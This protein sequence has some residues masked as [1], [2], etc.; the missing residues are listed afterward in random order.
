VA[1]G[2]APTEMAGSRN[3]QRKH[4]IFPGAVGALRNVDLPRNLSEVGFNVGVPVE[5]GI[6]AGASCGV[7][8]GGQGSQS[9]HGASG[10]RRQG[11]NRG[12]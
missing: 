2:A 1:V 6:A 12:Y 9:S 5:T 7:P 10:T 4:P 8:G 11:R 3:T